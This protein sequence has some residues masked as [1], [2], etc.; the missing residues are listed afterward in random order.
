VGDL[1]NVTVVLRFALTSLTGWGKM[2]AA[3]WLSQGAG[4]RK[5]GAFQLKLRGKLSPFVPSPPSEV[6]SRQHLGTIFPTRL[7]ILRA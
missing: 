3:T 7:H 2:L 6:P 5:F 4:K 1:H